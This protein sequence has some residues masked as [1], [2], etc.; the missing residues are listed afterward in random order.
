MYS[1]L[2]CVILLG[3][4]LKPKSTAKKLLQAVCNYHG[5][6]GASMNT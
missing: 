1:F 2:W 5:S 6:R 4:F 3:E